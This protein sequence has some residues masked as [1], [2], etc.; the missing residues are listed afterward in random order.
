MEMISSLKPNLW[1]SLADE[2]PSWVVEKRNKT[3]VDRTVRWLDECIALD[4]V[5]LFT[6][7]F[8]LSGRKMILN[9]C[10]SKGIQSGGEDILGAIVGGSSLEERRR[11]AKEVAKRNVSGLLSFPFLFF[12]NFTLR[13]ICDCITFPALIWIHR[14]IKYSCDGVKKWNVAYV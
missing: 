2:V 5:C 3:S 13:R 8:I 1:A 12:S 14:F 10:S 7:A 6:S 9:L 11:C 4:P